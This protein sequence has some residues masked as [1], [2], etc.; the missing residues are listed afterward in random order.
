MILFMHFIVVSFYLFQVRLYER[1]L[2]SRMIY[3]SMNVMLLVRIL[4]IDT[5]LYKP[6]VWFTE[7]SFRLGTGEV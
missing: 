5:S 2:L 4:F 6:V 1:K 7:L 3:V